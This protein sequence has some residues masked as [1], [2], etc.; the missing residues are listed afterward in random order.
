MKF[1]NFNREYHL[2]TKEVNSANRENK[3]KTEA[4]QNLSDK[5]VDKN[6]FTLKLI[7]VTTFFDKCDMTLFPQ[8][9]YFFHLLIL[10]LLFR[11]GII[12]YMQI[13]QHLC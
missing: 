4:V 10:L 8:K 11:R 1:I 7:P 6:I 5:N 9:Y 12:F 13:V 3:Q 2:I